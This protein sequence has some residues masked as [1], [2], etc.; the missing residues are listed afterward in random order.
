METAGL[1]LIAL[2]MPGAM[3]QSLGPGHQLGWW[4]QNQ[5]GVFSLVQINPDTVL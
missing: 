2:E 4:V 3:S 1:D 5:T